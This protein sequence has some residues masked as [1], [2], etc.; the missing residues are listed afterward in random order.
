MS[1]L[2]NALKKA[3]L[4][5]YEVKIRS[6]LSKYPDGLTA[7]EL[8]KIARVPHAKIYSVLNGLARHALLHSDESRPKKYY[9]LPADALA[10]ALVKPRKTELEQIQANPRESS[11]VLSD[12]LL[13][14]D[15]LIADGKKAGI[16]AVDPD[17]HEYVQES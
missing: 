7:E 10:D 11:R 8:S 4:T 13:R 9:P 3:G 16:P 5:D 12:D 14:T 2:E 6:S 17:T 1:S 15:V